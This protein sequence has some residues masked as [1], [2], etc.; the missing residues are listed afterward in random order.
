LEPFQRRCRALYDCEADNDDELSFY[1][2]ET[3]IA[4]KEE[5]EDWWQGYVEGQPHRHGMFPKTFV[6]VIESS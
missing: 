4:E 3:I 1:E 2:G 5:E 6:Q